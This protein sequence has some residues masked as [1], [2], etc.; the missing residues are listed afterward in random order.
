MPGD[1]IDCRH[2]GVGGDAHVPLFAAG[3]EQGEEV[4]AIGVAHEDA[5]PVIAT[6]GEVQPVAER[7]KAILAGPFASAE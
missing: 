5:L 3:F 4:L 2:D 7:G 6:L 1:A